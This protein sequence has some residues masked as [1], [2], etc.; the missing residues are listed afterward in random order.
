MVQR[1]ICI[2]L[3]YL[4]GLFQSGYFMGLLKHHDIRNY[5]SGNSG[6]TN[7]LRVFGKKA[8]AV[9]FIGDFLKAFIVWSLIRWGAVKFGLADRQVVLVLYGGLGAVLGHNFPF[10]LQ[11]RGGK[12][13]AASWGIALAIDWR[14]ALVCMIIFVAT[15]LITK[16]VSLASLLGLTSFVVMWFVLISLND[17]D[18]G[19]CGI[20]ASI[21]VLVIVL[22]GFVRHKSNIQRL[23]AGTENKLGQRVRLPDADGEKEKT[24]EKS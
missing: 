14:M 8:G 17:L 2:A 12:G 20:E 5:G 19:S 1:L 11:F 13:I 18:V 6:T 15:A 7:A 24:A 3:G 22:L 16:F 10:Y 9:V 21:V 4:F 23:L